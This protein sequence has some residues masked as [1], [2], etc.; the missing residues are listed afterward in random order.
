MRS[1]SGKRVLFVAPRFFGYERDV[2]RELERQGAIVNWLP[3]RPFD[4]P[5]MKALTKTYPLLV[6]PWASRLYERLLNEFSVT[7]YDIVLV[8]NGQTLSSSMLK[9]LRRSFPTAEYVLYMWDSIKNR[10]NICKNLD[11]FDRA[12]TFDPK[13]SKSFHMNFRPLFYANGFE[14]QK[15]CDSNPTKYHISFVGTA[16]TDRYAIVNSLR[17]RLPAHVIAY[18]YLYLQ[19]PWVLNLY[20]WTNPSMEDANVSDFEFIPLDKKTVQQVFAQSGAILDIE[21]PNQNGLTMRTFETLGAGK[22]LVTTNSDVRNYDFFN[23]NNIFV[24]DRNNPIISEQFF[25]IPFKELPLEIMNRYSIAGWLE[26]IL[27]L[28][29][30]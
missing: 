7:N 22:K 8:L 13:D 1:L 23:E 21:H 4:T 19:A 29:T 6:H 9:N 10:K 24:I 15:V 5:L 2:I 28:K 16:H 14:T 27:E 17:N 11:L 25:D 26:E 20:R 3:D 30:R 18:W 12:Y